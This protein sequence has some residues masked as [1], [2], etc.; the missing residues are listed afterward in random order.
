[1]KI[2]FLPGPEGGEEEFWVLEES[3]EI[4]HLAMLQV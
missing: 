3:S 2:C 4:E 1:M